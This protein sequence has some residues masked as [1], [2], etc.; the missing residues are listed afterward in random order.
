MILL[1]TAILSFGIHN[2]HQRTAITEGSI[3]G[4]V[5]LINHCVRRA[6][7]GGVAPARRGQLR[8]GVQISRVG[9]FALG[10]SGQREPGRVL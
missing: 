8:A 1:G 4:L 3:I 7:V 6:R 5:L 10:R 2:I 9:L